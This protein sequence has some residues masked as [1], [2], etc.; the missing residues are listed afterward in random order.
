VL[1]LLCAAQLMITIDGTVVNVALPSISRAL[2]FSPGAV[3]WVVTSYLL[4][5]AGLLLLSGRAADQFGRRAML[6][7]GL[8]LFTASSL[9]SGLAP[10]AAVLIVARGGQGVGAALLSPA[11]LSIITTTYAGRRRAAALSAWGAI[12]AGGFVAGLLV[13]G[14]VTTWLSWRWI[15]F[16]NLPVGAIALAGVLLLIGRDRRAGARLPMR[17]SPAGA[18]ELTGGL[19]AIVYALSAPLDWASARTLAPLGTGAL[20][21]AAFADRERRTVHPLLPRE[22]LRR[23]SLVAG[24]ALMLAVTGLLVGILFV[25]TFFLQQRLHQSALRTGLDYLPFAV[26]IGLAAHAGPRLLASFGSKLLAS[27]ALLI[28]C[29]GAVLLALAP[30]HPPYAARLL[31]AFL[32]LGAGTG[33]ALVSASVTA[34]SDIDPAHAGAASGLLTTGH[35]VGGALGVAVLSAVATSAGGTAAAGLRVAAGHQAAFVV[36]AVAAACL[37]VL[38]ALALPAA[39]PQPGTPHPLH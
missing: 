25:T 14:V 9:L 17:L 19:V 38:A 24:A 31:P 13:G 22:I 8:V 35:E 3:Q 30:A 2:G 16:I 11:A 4:C 37:A 21:L 10:S 33:F 39:R 34:M 1:I 23:R 32:L 36:V 7:A 6:V 18:L 27:T 26:M 12:G 28:I 15:F 29:G 20:L 5:T